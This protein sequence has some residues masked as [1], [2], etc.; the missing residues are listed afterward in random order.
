MLLL[1]AVVA[2]MEMG[3]E[4]THQGCRALIYKHNGDPTISY[5]TNFSSPPSPEERRKYLR[6]MLK[7]LI[8]STFR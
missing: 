6:S 1:L 8:D 2:V 3:H 7:Y 5:G 4:Q